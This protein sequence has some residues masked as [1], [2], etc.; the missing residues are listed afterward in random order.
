LPKQV[1]CF[2]TIK[3]SRWSAVPGL[4]GFSTLVFD[5]SRH[6]LIPFVTF[7]SPCLAGECPL[8]PGGY[9]V[10]KGTEKVSQQFH[11]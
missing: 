8:D 4:D 3:G 10:V 11:L 2:R 6:L 5:L 9:F 1:R 7:G